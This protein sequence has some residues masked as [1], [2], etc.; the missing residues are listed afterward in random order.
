[1]TLI[2]DGKMNFEAEYLQNWEPVNDAVFTREEVEALVY[3]GLA[4]KDTGWKL[5]RLRYEAQSEWMHLARPKVRKDVDLDYNF[6]ELM[7]LKARA[8]QLLKRKQLNP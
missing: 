5:L 6:Q 8:N 7:N 2:W 4:S 3:N 1:M